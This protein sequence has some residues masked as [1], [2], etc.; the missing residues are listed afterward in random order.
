METPPPSSPL[1][2]LPPLLQ[3]LPPLPPPVDLPNGL[4]LLIIVFFYFIAAS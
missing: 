4:S 3:L 1:Q 2:L